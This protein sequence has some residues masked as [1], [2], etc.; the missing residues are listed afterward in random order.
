MPSMPKIL[1][2][3]ALAG[4][5]ITLT[6]AA[7]AACPK[8]PASVPDS[9][10]PKIPPAGA[11]TPAPS[12]TN[13]WPSPAALPARCPAVPLIG[14]HAT[15]NVGPGKHYTDL[16]DVPWLNLVAGDVVNIYY[17]PTPYATKIAIRAKGTVDKPVI[18]NGVA[19]AHGNLPTITG[20]NA[21][22]A[23]DAIKQKFF[24]NSGGATIEP[25]GVIDLYRGYADQYGYKPTYVTIQNLRITGAGRGNTFTDHSG[26]LQTF[27]SFASGIYAVS[28]QYLTIQ[29]NEIFQN[30]LGVFVNNQNDTAGTSFFTT[31]RGN[32]IHDD[33]VV[34]DYLEHNVYVQGVRSLYE[35]NYIGQLIPGAPGGSLKD[36]SSGPVV[37]YNY[38]VSAARAIDL[39]D[40]EN[41]SPDTNADPLYNYGWVYGNV[42]V[43][44]FSNPG[45]GSGDLIHWGGDSYEFPQYHNG[46]LYFYNNTVIVKATQAQAYSLSVFD[47][48]TRRQSMVVSN[49]VI[50]HSGTSELDYCANSST[51]GK[52][53]IGTLKIVDANWIAKAVDSGKCKV[54]A[55]R[56]VAVKG[57]PVL[58]PDFHLKANSPASGPGVAYM[59]GKLPQPASVTG[60]R[61]K[62][63]YT[64]GA[65]TAV[66]PSF[67]ARKTVTDLGAYSYP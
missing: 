21:V 1:L 14:S 52:R 5:S 66:Q 59:P 13:S 40:S 31:L 61:V 39:V 19:D 49:N 62:D 8:A 46:P 51:D 18:I 55:S 41:G 43:D 65:G 53:G 12:L 45:G 36:R 28:A 4:L 2:T 64:P 17:S 63:Q 23:K 58:T 44:D 27:P 60:L 32:Y 22:T 33:G 11:P 26:K 48:A 67:V 35:G 3:A 30:G 57:Q 37:R 54:D 29:Y 34:N 56:A 15:Y 47:M 50:A 24:V 16:A 38:I 25:F 7:L 9:P 6:N 42:I 20:E 10:T